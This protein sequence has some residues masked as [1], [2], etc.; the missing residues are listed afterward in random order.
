LAIGDSP[1]A[2][3]PS[4]PEAEAEESW[5]NRPERRCTT[6]S[7]EKC[8]RLLRLGL[9]V[10]SCEATF[11]RLLSVPMDAVESRE[12]RF[13]EAE[14]AGERR[15]ARLF[16]RPLVR[17]LSGKLA[18]F[19]LEPLVSDA[20][21]SND[22]RADSPLCW[23]CETF[24]PEAGCERRNRVLGKLNTSGVWC[25]V[26]VLL[27]KG[28][29]NLASSYAY[30]LQLGSTQSGRLESRTRSLVDAAFRQE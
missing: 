30:R 13:K 8:T 27:H 14:L 11:R 21:E 23:L 15:D 20:D 22:S 28:E 19:R 18:R 6:S 25:E 7:G 4:S 2:A 9:S 24:S 29:K 10:D 17:I 26:H 5:F 1:S 16:L 12:S 3:K